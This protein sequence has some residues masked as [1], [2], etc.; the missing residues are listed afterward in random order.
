MLLNNYTI[1][2][3]ITATILITDPFQTKIQKLLPAF[4]MWI[5]AESSVICCSKLD[6][7]G[8]WTVAQK[9]NVVSS[10]LLNAII[11]QSDDCRS[12]SQRE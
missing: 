8:F 10:N 1:D 6:S 5:F 3:N 2:E 7:Y 9:E 11:S 4:Q 12:V